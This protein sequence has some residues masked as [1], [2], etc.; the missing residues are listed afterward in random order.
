MPH[1]WVGDQVSFPSPFPQF[2]F[3]VFSKVTDMSE[4][5][6]HSN[7][8]EFTLD[9]SLWLPLLYL[10]RVQPSFQ[11]L[12]ALTSF[13]FWNSD[14]KNVRFCGSVVGTW[15]A[16]HWLLFCCCFLPVAQKVLLFYL[17]VHWP[18]HLLLGMGIQLRGL[19]W[20]FSSLFFS[21]FEH[22]SQC[23]RPMAALKYF[24]HLHCVSTGT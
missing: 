21:V 2:I 17:P 13:S 10:R 9:L 15:G 11:V 16:A 3:S 20:G 8:F 4:C 19:R 6:I 18:L 7:S 22:T 23:I 14:D 24:Q 5:W 1:K 12:L